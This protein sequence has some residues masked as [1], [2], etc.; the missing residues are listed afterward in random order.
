MKLYYKKP[1]DYNPSRYNKITG[2]NQ[3]NKKQEIYYSNEKYHILVSNKDYD[4]LIS[5]PY[6]TQINFPYHVLP[7]EILNL[8]NKY[9]ELCLKHD[10][11]IKEDRQGQDLVII[12]D[13]LI[14][15]INLCYWMCHTTY[16]KNVLYK[17]FKDELLKINNVQ[18]ISYN[19]NI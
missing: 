10:L 6:E 14:I 3:T 18:L 2:E 11:P 17:D 13:N 16:F 7:S 12:Y 1:N 19:A 8:L 5:Y 15:K 4:Y 9:S